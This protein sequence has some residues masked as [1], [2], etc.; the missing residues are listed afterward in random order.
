[1]DTSDTRYVFNLGTRRRP[2]FPR[3]WR[4]DSDTH[5]A[6]GSRAGSPVV[7]VVDLALLRTLFKLTHYPSDTHQTMP[8]FWGSFD[9]LPNR[10]E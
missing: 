3:F 2:S 7:R 9:N 6:G 10:L 4:R 1:M 5:D 8:I